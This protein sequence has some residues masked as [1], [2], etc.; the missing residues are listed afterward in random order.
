MVQV[1]EVCVLHQFG[2]SCGC[3][4][5][6]WTEVDFNLRRFWTELEKA[7]RVDCFDYFH[8]NILHCM[9]L[10]DDCFN[11]LCLHQIE[12]SNR[13]RF[14]PLCYQCAFCS[15]HHNLSLFRGFCSKFPYWCSYIFYVLLYQSLLNLL[16]DISYAFKVN[17]YCLKARY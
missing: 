17:I 8:C 7:C 2:Y 12:I 1:L 11:N 16:V 9:V 14:A 5:W 3:L 6:D 13:V 10:D 15:F 4:Q